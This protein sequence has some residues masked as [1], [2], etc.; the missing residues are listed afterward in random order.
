M[1]VGETGIV[2]ISADA[3]VLVAFLCD[4]LLFVIRR[5]RIDS[6]ITAIVRVR[7][8]STPGITG[9]LFGSFK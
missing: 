4:R 3:L 9:P 7:I 6:L 1:V 8:E 5:D 2:L